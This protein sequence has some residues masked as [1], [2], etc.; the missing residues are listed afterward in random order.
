MASDP[1]ESPSLL[2]SLIGLIFEPRNTVE[3]LLSEDRPRHGLSL[4]TLLLLAVFGPIAY[5]FY[6]LGYNQ[7][8]L[9]AASALLVLILFTIITFLMLESW[10]FILLGIDASPSAIYSCLS[11][12]FGPLI[13][14][15]ILVYTFNYISSGT[16]SLIDVLVVGKALISERFLRI[17]PI[18]IA[19]VQINALLVFFSGV[20]YI[21]HM[22]PITAV[23]VSLFSLIIFYIAFAAGLFVAESIHHGIVD[24]VVALMTSPVKGKIFGVVG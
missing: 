11:Y 13:L 18:A 2:E 16:F 22:H 7:Q 20:K 9:T 3:A 12:S 19:I 8:S 10:L 4:L 23:A 14:A 1:S 5:Q 15:V 24:L 6:Y 17:F 21:G